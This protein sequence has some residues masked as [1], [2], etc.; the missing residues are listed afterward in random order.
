MKFKKLTILLL[1][2]GLISCKSEMGNTDKVTKESP[3]TSISSESNTTTN[4]TQQPIVEYYQN[5][6]GIP[7][8]NGFI[9]ADTTNVASGNKYIIDV[10]S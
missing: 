4:A 2:I 7:I 1:I 6:N 5:E 8:Y 9:D 10:I 3:S